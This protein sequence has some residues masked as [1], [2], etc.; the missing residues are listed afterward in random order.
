MVLRVLRL[1]LLVSAVAG[2][3]SVAEA[4]TADLTYSR[5]IKPLLDLRCV[6]CHH[7]GARRPDLSRF[8]FRTVVDQ[9][10]IV[11]KILDKVGGIVGNIYPR[12][13]DTVQTL[14]ALAPKRLA[15]R[16]RATAN[17]LTK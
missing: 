6:E 14:A 5:D 1:G 2:T 7:D 10:A 13:M 12:F 17:E 8:P 16:W 11:R 9:E 4:G 15:G 3:L